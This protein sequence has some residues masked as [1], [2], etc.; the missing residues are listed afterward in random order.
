MCAG[1]PTRARTRA[2]SG[3]AHLS[4]HAGGDG[5]RR[6]LRIEFKIA[7]R[8]VLIGALVLEKYDLAVGLP[9]QLKADRDLRHRR[10]ACNSAAGIDLAFAVCAAY[11]DGALADRREYGVAVC[12]IEIRGD[13]LVAFEHVDR[14]GVVLN[15]LAGMDNS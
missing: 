9:P 11:A 3:R 13:G 10:K 14:P 1:T 7:A 8:E 6:S 5:D 15:G 12:R 2:S 4:L